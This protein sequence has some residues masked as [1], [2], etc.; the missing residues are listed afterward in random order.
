[1]DA[2]AEGVPGPVTPVPQPITP[3]PGPVTPVVRDMEAELAAAQARI[4]ALEERS[5]ESEL[6]APHVADVRAAGLQRA[7]SNRR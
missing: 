2:E 6:G 3:V 1:M 7:G 5:G 4:S